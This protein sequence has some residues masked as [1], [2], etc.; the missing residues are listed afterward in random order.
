ME[1]TRQY[2][3]SN[4]KQA[5][6][7]RDDGAWH[8][9]GRRSQESLEITLKGILRLLGLEVPKR[10]EVSCASGNTGTTSSTGSRST[11]IKLCPFPGGCIKMEE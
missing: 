9:A 11:A 2:T 1:L 6:L 4:L 7:A 10:H 3:E 8:L 5:K